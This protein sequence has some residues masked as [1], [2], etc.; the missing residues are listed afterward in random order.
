MFEY[1]P[2]IQQL[3]YYLVRAQTKKAMM[4]NAPSIISI[5]AIDPAIMGIGSLLEV[6]ASDSVVAIYMGASKVKN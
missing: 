6:C 4:Q 5:T 1:Q 3:P 2:C